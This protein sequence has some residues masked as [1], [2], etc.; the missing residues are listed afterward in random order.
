MIDLT[1][2]G[3]SSPFQQK[4]FEITCTA[5]ANKEISVI[6]FYNN[7]K[8]RS[9][10][11]PEATNTLVETMN[12]WCRNIQ[13]LRQNDLHP[14]AFSSVSKISQEIKGLKDK[15]SLIFMKAIRRTSSPKKQ[16]PPTVTLPK[17]KRATIE[18]TEEEKRY[19]KYLLYLAYLQKVSISFQRNPRGP[20]HCKVEEVTPEQY[21]Q[22][23]KT[24]TR[25]CKKQYIQEFIQQQ[26]FS[27][28]Q[29]PYITFLTR[30]VGHDL[31]SYQQQE[32]IFSSLLK[33]DKELPEKACYEIGSSDLI[34]LTA[35]VLEAVLP[36]TLSAS[37]RKWEVE[38]RF[39]TRLYGTN[40]SG[41][42]FSHLYKKLSS[43]FESFLQYS[44]RIS[45]L[46]KKK[47]TLD[48][49]EYY[50]FILNIHQKWRETWSF[51]IPY[52]SDMKNL[53]EIIL[54]T[55]TKDADYESYQREQDE[56][57]Y[58]EKLKTK[59]TTI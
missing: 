17:I 38:G 1:P 43:S 12:I 31:L 24:I 50:T 21:F 10:L 29:M 53:Q 58:A 27:V 59:E 56:K 33:I 42:D 7:I 4:V 19:D 9:K 52:S 57:A 37:F 35:Q 39:F 2:D 44:A 54:D 32:R 25:L 16:T 34:H 15:L 48:S 11:S 13:S 45:G 14:A 28:R 41:K 3:S 5:F 55:L 22:M 40:T 30:F 36:E 46:F 26:F 20:L 23:K 49:G 8:G 47:Q 6:D 18:K 51:D